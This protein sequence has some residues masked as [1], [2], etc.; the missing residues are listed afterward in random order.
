MSDVIK[1]Q[2]RFHDLES[3]KSQGT[4]VMKAWEDVCRKT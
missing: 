3:D 2:A 1:C 4:K